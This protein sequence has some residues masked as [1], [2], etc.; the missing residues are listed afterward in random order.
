MNVDSDKTIC[1]KPE[2]ISRNPV[3]KF[4]W[5]PIPSGKYWCDW[6]SSFVCDSCNKLYAW[7]DFCTHSCNDFAHTDIWN[8][9]VKHSYEREQTDLKCNPGDYED[10]KYLPYGV[11]DCFD[12]EYCAYDADC[13]CSQSSEKKVRLDSIFDTC[14]ENFK[15]TIFGEYEQKNNW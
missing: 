12:Q 2:P 6:G 9:C 15:A 4:W 7:G 5:D 13:Y 3:F 14:N 10:G 8:Q 1:K 11:L